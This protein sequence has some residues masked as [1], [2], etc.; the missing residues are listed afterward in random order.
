MY[1]TTGLYVPTHRPLPLSQID[2]AR[3]VA[4]KSSAAD[5]HEALRRD[6]IHTARAIHHRLRPLIAALEFDSN[7]VPVKYALHVALGLSPDVRLPLV[8]AEA[9]TA[10]AIREALAA[11]D[12]TGDATPQL[13][14]G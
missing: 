13:M 2:H 6:D 10:K 1:R 11:L 12:E 8:P 3:S 7:P 9:E 5:M 14:F 4:D